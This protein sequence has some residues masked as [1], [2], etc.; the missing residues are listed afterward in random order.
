ML[1]FASWLAKRDDVSFLLLGVAMTVPLPDIYWGNAM[2]PMV[3]AIPLVIRE[4]RRRGED[5]RQLDDPMSVKPVTQC[6]R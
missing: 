4:T 6:L 1:L 2:V 3:S 5:Q